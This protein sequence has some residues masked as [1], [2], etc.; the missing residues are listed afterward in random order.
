MSKE[1]TTINFK[2]IDDINDHRATDSDEVV[3]KINDIS[4]MYVRNGMCYL[5][6]DDWD[7]PYQLTVIDY[8]R[9][10]KI[11]EAQP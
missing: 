11:F 9:I 4:L 6:A 1:P 5:Q 7:T 2:P 8:N 10:K 3:M